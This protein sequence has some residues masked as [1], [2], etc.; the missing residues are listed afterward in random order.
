MAEELP[1]N[2]AGCRSAEQGEQFE[3]SPLRAALRTT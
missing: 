2:D 1:A 3:R